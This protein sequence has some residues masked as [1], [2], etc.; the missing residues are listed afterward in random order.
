MR[1]HL[2]HL[3]AVVLTLSFVAIFVGGCAQPA[4]AG[5]TKQAPAGEAKAAPAGEAKAAPKGEVRIG[6]LIPY[7]GMGAAVGKMVEGGIQYV[8]EEANWEVAGK[9]IVLIKEDETDDPNNAVAKARK[10]VEQDKVDVILGPM[11]AHSGAAVGA[12]LAPLGIPHMIMGGADFGE[13]KDTFYP[14]SGRGDVAPSGPFAYEDLGAKTAAVLY[15]DYLYG[16]ELADGFAAGFTS[17][18]GKVVSSQAVPVGTADMIPYLQAIRKTDLLAVFLVNPSDFAFVRQYQELGLKMPVL[19][20]SNAPQEEPLLAQ[21]GDGVL[22][23]YGLSWYSPQVDTPFN[24]TFV[25]KYKSKFGALPGIMTHTSYMGAALFLQAFKA[26]GGDTDH[27]KVI[28]AMKGIKNLDT[29]NGPI[30]MTAGRIAIKDEFVF[31]A[32][33]IGDRYAWDP[34]KKYPAVQ[35]K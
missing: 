10:L 23:M 15:A 21:M 14:G 32:V 2:S 30:S 24:K 27:A 11:L 7:T 28:E 18:G 12:Y 19:F 17:K 31:K 25:E 20:I 26:T 13:S 33:K 8:L 29:P 34:V 16:Q 1:R 5:E 3:L 6:A 4:P 22:G 35:P 9:K